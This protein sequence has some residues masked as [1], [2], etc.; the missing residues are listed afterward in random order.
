MVKFGLFAGVWFEN[1]CS[2]SSPEPK[3]CPEC[4]QSVTMTQ[5]RRIYFNLSS[6]I[7][8]VQN[9]ENY[10]EYLD[11][12]I[13]TKNNKL[14]MATMQLEKLKYEWMTKL[15]EKD[16]EIQRLTEKLKHREQDYEVQ[17]LNAKI[18]KL[19]SKLREVGAIVKFELQLNIFQFHS[20]MCHVG[21]LSFSVWVSIFRAATSMLHIQSKYRCDSTPSC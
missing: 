6:I 16:Y 14:H 5:T 1:D 13:T 12:V 20:L 15:R 4:R 11:T 8:N 19:K 17:K 3:T 21:G 10:V 2:V 18:E 7:D 9:M